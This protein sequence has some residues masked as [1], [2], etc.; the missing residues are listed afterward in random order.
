MFK[1]DKWGALS[2]DNFLAD[3]EKGQANHEPL[4]ACCRDW[5]QSRAGSL[6]AGLRVSGRWL[7]RKEKTPARSVGDLILRGEL[8]DEI[9]EEEHQDKDVDQLGRDLGRTRA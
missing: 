5:G 9:G 8:I 2:K 4:T 6:L 7:R 3:S 1:K